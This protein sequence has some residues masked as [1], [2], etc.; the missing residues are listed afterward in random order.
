MQALFVSLTDNYFGFR[1]TIFSTK[2]MDKGGKEM[3]SK[4]LGLSHSTRKGAK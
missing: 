3:H 2:G 1:E 4:P